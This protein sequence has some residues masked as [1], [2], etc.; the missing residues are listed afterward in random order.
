MFRFLERKEVTD[1]H[2]TLRYHF[3]FV[4]SNSEALVVAVSKA[5]TLNNTILK[6]LL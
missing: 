6:F 3:K 1:V 5:K 2:L 4:D